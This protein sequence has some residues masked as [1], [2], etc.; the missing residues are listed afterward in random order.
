MY[1]YD[2]TRARRIMLGCKKFKV[3][4]IECNIGAQKS[5]EDLA[6]NHCYQL[7]ID[8]LS[9][10]RAH[11][12]HELSQETPEEE[13]PAED[14]PVVKEDVEEEQNTSTDERLSALL[15]RKL[16]L[17]TVQNELKQ[18]RD[19]QQLLSNMEQVGLN[20]VRRVTSVL[21]P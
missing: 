10:V 15:R 9:P 16:E 18:L 11:S 6:V 8:E 5:D 2:V 12:A 14:L 1:E 7:H 3:V 13:E 17:E 21:R 20:R 4:T 19:Q